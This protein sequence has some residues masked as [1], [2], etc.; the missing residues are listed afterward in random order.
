MRAKHLVKN[1]ETAFS[2][3]FLDLLIEIG[4]KFQPKPMPA[5]T[6]MPTDEE[7]DYE[8]ARRLA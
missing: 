2:G 5:C 7:S 8:M 1:P 4:S 6:P 3:H